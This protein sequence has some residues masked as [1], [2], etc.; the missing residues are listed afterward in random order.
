[1]Q[2]RTA[3]LVAA[4]ATAT[5]AQAQTVN[6]APGSPVNSPALTGFQ[7]QGQN[8][9]GMRVT[10]TFVDGSIFSDSWRD[11]TGGFH[12]AQVAGRFRLAM[13]ST[14]DSFTSNWLFSS[15]ATGGPG[16]RSVR[17]E[18]REGRTLFDSCW[19][20]RN[21]CTSNIEGTVGS[22]LGWTFQTTGGSYGGS[23]TALYTNL[24]GVGGD[25]PVGDLFEELNFRF[26]ADLG[27]IGGQSYTF[28]ADTD[29]SRFDAPP[30]QIV[31]EPSTYALL[32]TG[33]AGL[34]AV[35]R[36][37]RAVPRT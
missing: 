12:G 6:F 3:V 13:G 22:A 14:D 24:V 29:N 1:M 9:V 15:L 19:R 17:V 31:P 18:G 34:S 36:R 21:D 33:L 35:A 25:A 8:M 5:T 32:A 16:V 2:V 20:T 7:T 26:D 37:R 4:M 27:L 30:P 23:V 11:L 10:A 28:R